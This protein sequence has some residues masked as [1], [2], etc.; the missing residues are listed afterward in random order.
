MTP[1]PRNEG[2]DAPFEM[3]ESTQQNAAVLALIGACTMDHATELGDAIM[4]VA[5]AADRL[6]IL[7]LSRL[8]FIESTNLGKIVAGYLHLRKRHGDLRLV[9]PK[10]QIRELLDLTRLSTLFG[11]FN[12]LPD[13]INHQPN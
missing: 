5:Q 9:A 7:D 8:D 1:E 4:K 13:A 2:K 10:P 6:V 12:T 11:V 3:R